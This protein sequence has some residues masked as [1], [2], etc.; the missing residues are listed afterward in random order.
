MT[1]KEYNEICDILI[2]LQK[3]FS[4]EEDK[5][6]EISRDHSYRIDELEQQ[7]DSAR[8]SED[9]DF[10]VFSPRNVSLDNS[11]KISNLESEKSS[12]EKEKKEAD[13]NLGYYSGKAEKISKVLL[14]LK[15]SFEPESFIDDDDEEKEIKINEESSDDIFTPKKKRHNP[16]AF[17]E[18]DVEEEIS[19][20]DESSNVDQLFNESNIE[21]QKSNFDELII[22]EDDSKISIK[23]SGVPV[24][25]VQRVC[26]KVEFSE[27]II[28]NDRVRAKLELKEIITELNEL[29][30]AYK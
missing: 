1:N 8:R 7:I 28:N 27:K 9:I 23:S 26:H 15:K 29:I 24:D 12:L 11:E 4:T 25:E 17:L 3:E 30:K 20:D 21:I 19:D 10:R 18:E 14:I 2:S 5:L 13:K 6:K 16:F 22:D